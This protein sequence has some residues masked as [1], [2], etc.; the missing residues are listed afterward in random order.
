MEAI[1]SYILISAICLSFCYLGFM[2]LQRNE[3]KLNH[4]RLYLLLSMFLVLFLPFSKVQIETPDFLEVKEIS[5]NENIHSTPLVNPTN[6]ELVVTQPS[7]SQ[8]QWSEFLVGLYVVVVSL[9]LIRMIFHLLM[10]LRLFVTSV[11]IRQDTFIVLV[12]PKIQSPFSFFKWIFISE[13]FFD[14]EDVLHHE[15]VHAS[16]YHSLDILLIE[17]LAAVMWFNPFVWMMR[18]SVQLVHEYLAD[19]GVLRTGIDRLQYQALLVNQIA[20]GNL[21]CLSSGFHHSLIK[22]RLIMMTKSKPDRDPKLR[23][24]TIIPIAMFLFLGV[25]YINGQNSNQQ[26]PI[27]K[28]EVTATAKKVSIKAKSESTQENGDT[29]PFYILNDKQVSKEAF[30]AIPPKNIESI[31][32]TRRPL[33]EEDHGKMVK[34]LKDK[35]LFDAY[36]SGKYKA[37]MIIKLK[38]NSTTKRDKFESWI[39]EKAYK[40]LILKDRF[41]V[42]S[43]NK[44]LTKE[45]YLSIDP[46]AIDSIKITGGVQTV[47]DK[48][49]IKTY[50]KN[51]GLYEEYASGNYGAVLF[52]ILKR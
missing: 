37:V 36:I 50:L 39:T 10:L 2:I 9:L 13:D 16:Q 45:Q 49:K 6:V 48:D 46:F 31:N 19:E 38:E 5:A 14:N 52:V 7:S 24:L 12:N 18:K 4:L 51:N 22:K 34:Y 8:I 29:N 27:P 33:F 41:F 32:V 35:G 1:Q 44:H 23:I 20:E 28:K 26:K 11:R 17:L 15:K 21:I 42:V 3:T 43:N 47:Q 40:D 30:M 25:A